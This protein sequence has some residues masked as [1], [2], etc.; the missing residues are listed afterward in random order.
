MNDYAH[1]CNCHSVCFW[2]AGLIIN[3]STYSEILI[4]TIKHLSIKMEICQLFDLIL[5][6]LCTS[7]IQYHS[8]LSTI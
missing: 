5:S 4:E 7:V 1:L 3:N 6:N 2:A 8:I